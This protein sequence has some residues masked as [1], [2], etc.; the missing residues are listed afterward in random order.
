MV[1]GELA[2]CAALRMRDFLHAALELDQREV[3][4]R[5]R[6]RGGAI[7]HGAADRTGLCHREWSQNQCAKQRQTRDIPHH[8][9]LRSAAEAGRPP[10][11]RRT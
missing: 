8:W 6:L 11:G 7:F 2:L 5:R 10:R 1:E 3:N 4:S 9:A